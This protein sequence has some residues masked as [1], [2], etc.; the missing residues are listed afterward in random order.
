MKKSL[1][2][3]LIAASVVAP[4]QESWLGLFMQNKKIGY[5]SNLVRNDRLH[6]L[7]MTRSDTHTLISA[8]LLGTSMTMDMKSSTW[9]SAG[10]PRRMVFRMESSDRVQSMH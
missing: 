8:G 5:S 4:A 7:R 2:V 10:K 9:I 6:G 1:L 3:L